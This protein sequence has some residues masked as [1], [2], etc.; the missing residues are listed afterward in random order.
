MAK[1]FNLLRSRRRRL[2]QDLDR[3]L[4]YHVDRRIEDLVA[5]DLSEANARRRAAIEF[6]G[7]AQVRE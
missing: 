4:R 7:L 1:I 2:E 3:E 5:A 6:G